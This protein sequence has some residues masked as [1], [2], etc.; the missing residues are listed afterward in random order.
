MIWAL[1]GAFGS[2]S[3]WDALAAALDAEVR[4]VD[5]W[6][7][8]HDLPLSEWGADFNRLVADCDP[9][10]ILLGYSMG[11]RLGLHALLAAP[12][13]W[14]SAILVSPHPGLGSPKARADR[15][16]Q[17]DDWLRRF[18][19][20]DWHE[21]W[22]E[23]NAQDVFESAA[24]RG[25]P[26]H[27]REMR[28]GLAAWSVSEQRDLL[29]Q[30]HRIKCPVLWVTGS[31]DAKFTAIAEGIARLLPDSR[32]HV[33]LDAGHRV[34]WDSPDAFADLLRDVESD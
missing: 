32:H 15:R 33:V 17:D 34:P 23:W 3:D 24:P 16:T 29:P 11:A 12:G 9:E 26:V 8:E 28:R 20:L 4:P 6:A 31:R 1:H 27:R 21:F 5:L 30:L 10:P 14:K 22:R 13:L 25:Q 7:P 2:S 18:D 19:G